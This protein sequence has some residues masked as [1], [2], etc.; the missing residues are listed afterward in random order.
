MNKVVNTW[1]IPSETDNN[2]IDIP[3]DIQD[4]SKRFVYG[5]N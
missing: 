2:A 1:H 3:D 4:I 5:V